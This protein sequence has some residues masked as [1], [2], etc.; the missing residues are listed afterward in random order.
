VNESASAGLLFDY[1]DATVTHLVMRDGI[2]APLR[3]PTR[4][5]PVKGQ[6]GAPK[7][8]SYQRWPATFQLVSLGLPITHR[9]PN[10]QNPPTHRLVIEEDG[11]LDHE[12]T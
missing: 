4:Q 6:Q 3:L 2:A 7:A 11:D 9:P 1:T 5:T 10:L 8:Q 12:A